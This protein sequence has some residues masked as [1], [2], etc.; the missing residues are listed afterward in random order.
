[1]SKN[2][3][4]TSP[5]MARLTDEIAPEKL[6][7]RKNRRFSIGCELVRSHAAKMPST[8]SPARPVPM[9]TGDVQPRT[10]AS[11]IDH[12]ISASPVIEA[13]APV[14]SGRS[15]AGFFE[16]G[17]SGMAHSRPA[18]AIGTLIKNTD[19]HQKWASSTPP[20]IGPKAKPT[21]LVPAQKPIAR[22]RS[23]ASRNT[24]VMIDKVDGIIS[25]APTP[26]LARAAI[27]TPTEPE[28]ADHAEPPANATRPA[29][30]VRLRPT[31]S[32]RLPATSN[33]PAKTS[34]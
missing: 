5:N 33:S 26:M 15:V 25:A 20:T 8:T 30:N 1:V 27:S 3:D 23:R 17:T 14:K 4:P 29:R 11:M 32:A 18:A 16:S 9:T 22:C 12:R 19:P 28:K 24:S 21:P 2:S 13:T 31:R 10:G 34:A 6:R 7:L